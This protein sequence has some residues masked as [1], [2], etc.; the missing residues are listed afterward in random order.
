MQYPSIFHRIPNQLSVE[1]KAVNIL[2]WDIEI[3]NKVFPFQ[4]LSIII[5]K[6]ANNI[7]QQKRKFS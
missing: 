3:C 6:R 4:Y 5:I 7:E 1:E 2:C